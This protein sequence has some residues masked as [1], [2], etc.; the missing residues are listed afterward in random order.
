MDALATF[1]SGV[2]SVLQ[3]R[4]DYALH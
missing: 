4:L 3:G 2:S 1:L